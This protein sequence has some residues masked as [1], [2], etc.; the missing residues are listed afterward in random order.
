LKDVVENLAGLKHVYGDNLTVF[1]NGSTIDWVVPMLKENFDSVAVSSKN[2]GYWS[3]IDWWLNNVEQGDYTYI[4]ESDMVHYA[5]WKLVGALDYLEK[6]PDVGSVRCHDYDV[7]NWKLYDKNRPQSNSKRNIWQ[8]HINKVTH[9]PITHTLKSQDPD[10]YETNFLTQLPALNRTAAIEK[11]FD[12]LI[13]M[14][15]GGFTEFDFQKMYWSQY[16]KTGIIDG[17]IFHCDG[18]SWGKP[19]VTGS[20]TDPK[21]LQKIGYQPTRIATIVPVSEYEVSCTKA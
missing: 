10:I 5:M 13:G 3:A 8:S 9:E 6:N 18:G 7:A 1:D 12:E 17:G 14:G 21:Q 11:C 4:I 16:Q 20:W 2:V 15:P 19:V